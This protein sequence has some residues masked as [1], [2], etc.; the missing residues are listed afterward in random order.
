MA[1]D[2]GNI[3]W[4]SQFIVTSPSQ[5]PKL[6]GDKITLPHSALE[7]LLAAAPLQEISRASTRNPTRPY[8]SNFDPFNSHNAAEFRARESGSDRQ[9]QL[10]HPLTF[11]VVNPRNDRVVYAG[12]REFSAEENEVGL[13]GFIRGALGIEDD[14]LRTVDVDEDT[15]TQGS[16]PTVTVHARQLPKG[17]Y[18]RLRPLEA[19]Y[20]PEDWKALLERHLRDNYTTLTTNE[21]LAVPGD[22][23]ESFRFLVDKVAPEGDGICVVD[24]D[25]EVDIV[26]LTED[27][28]RETFNK[29]LEKASR[30]P[31]VKGGTSVGGALRPGEVIAGRVMPGDYVDY[32]LREW[33]R[34]GTIEVEVESGDDASVYVFASPLSP[35]HRSRPREDSHVFSDFD[36][37]ERKRIRIQPTNVELEQVEALY[38]SVH[39]FAPLDSA[40]V[41]AGQVPL[42]YNLRLAI[43]SSDDEQAPEHDMDDHDPEDIQCKNCQQW[44]PQ[45]TLVLHENF[46]LRNNIYCA[47]CGNVFQKRSPEWEAHW[48]CPHDSSYGKDAPSKRI[49]DVIF[50][51]QT[52]CQDCGFEARNIPSLAQHRTTE[53]PSKPILCQ[54]CHLVVPQQGEGDPDLHD[55]EVL[56]SGL[57]PHELID[58]SRTT[59]CHLCN[60]IIR[61]RDMQTHLR[62]HDLDRVSR[63]PPR[64]CSNQNCGRVLDSQRSKTSNDTLGLCNICFGP[65][66]V[67][68]HDPEGKA[69]RRRIERR[70]LSQM[71]TGCGKAWCRNKYCKT[72]SSGTDSPPLPTSAASILAAARPLINALDLDPKSGSPNTAP[73]YLCADQAGQQRRIIAE[74]IAAEGPGAGGKT[75]DLPWCIAAVETAGGDI[76]KSREWLENWAP[77][78]GEDSAAFR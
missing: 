15:L 72:G 13:S 55:A 46:C 52:S 6:P 58:G 54:F 66:Y 16:A 3:R 4:S 21:V 25:L 69:L 76:E 10:P 1:S 39:A 49:H 42:E 30:A 50:H 14:Q 12:I 34:E 17:T 63:S 7:Q 26:A 28:A 71:M 24:T 2:Q 70:Y 19:G 37:R 61:L 40:A 5:T 11:R 41:D 33:D 74:L 43:N 51:T 23:N 53:C 48:H 9:H 18:V 35:R 45:R 77:A 75:Y 29:R 27:Q 57:T 68:T 65:L 56:L 47:Q 8:A 64:V 78:R 62:H 67:D 20:D 36:G 31:G 38:I 60:K 59:E 73:F 32:E 44:V 22:R